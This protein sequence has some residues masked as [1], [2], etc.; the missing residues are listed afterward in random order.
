MEPINAILFKYVSNRRTLFY[1][2]YHDGPWWAST[3]AERRLAAATY[4]RAFPQLF[5]SLNATTRLHAVQDLSNNIFDTAHSWPELGYLRTV[6]LNREIAGHMRYGQ[7]RDHT[8]HSCLAFVL[9]AYLVETV[10]AVR[11]CAEQNMDRVE[12]AKCMNR[13]TGY[14]TD[15]RRRLAAFALS[16]QDLVLSVLHH[17]IGYLFEGAYD[18]KAPWSSNGDLSKAAMAMS[19]F[20][21]REWPEHYF[22]GGTAEAYAFYSVFPPP[23]I[24][25]TS[26][27]AAAQSL[28]TVRFVDDATPGRLTVRD[29]FDVFR[30]SAGLRG[31]AKVSWTSKIDYME[32]AFERLAW[33]GIPKDSMRLLDH[34]VA[35][36]LLLLQLS[37][38]VY[39]AA[40]IACG[41]TSLP[42][43]DD[44][45]RALARGLRR[46]LSKDPQDLTRE[47]YE[48]SVRR[49][50]GAAF[51]NMSP[52]WHQRGNRAFPLRRRM[53]GVLYLPML[54]D[55]LQDW[56]RPPYPLDMRRRTLDGLSV[57]GKC[58]PG[59]GPFQ[60]YVADAA[61][62]R[63]I[64]KDL[65][66]R[67]SGW[68]H[69]VR[70][71]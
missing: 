41:R 16:M 23:V 27:S 2:S 14:S 62:R 68:R 47:H 61:R 26:L 22:V 57:R 35:S 63:A 31:A 52:S 21:L 50:A 39:E 29:A 69:M 11:R 40:K 24:D 38:Y 51:H 43:T 18:P 28:R 15:R 19:D 9:G 4:E 64:A 17:D 45:R 65:N 48:S 7:Y 12:L 58:G 66:S 46:V 8:I 44:V 1:A 49:I 59:R 54:L 33:E 56:D 36:G 42:V 60:L 3:A 32:H 34:G 25:A 67:L 71:H 13:L 20:F 37:T 70:L 5:M 6:V 53:L 55:V 30:T 10:D